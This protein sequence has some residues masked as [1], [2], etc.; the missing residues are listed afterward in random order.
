MAGVLVVDG[1]HAFLD[2]VKIDLIAHAHDPG[3]FSDGIGLLELLETDFAVD[4]FV[5]ELRF[6]A[7]A[8]N[9]H[10]LARMARAR[11]PGLKVVYV[12]ASSELAAEVSGLLPDVIL[13]SGCT[14]GIVAALGQGPVQ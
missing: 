1:N 14:N 4:A 11:R 10:A 8:P 6:R 7:G 13:K 3:G 5:T 9:G 12:T 2:V